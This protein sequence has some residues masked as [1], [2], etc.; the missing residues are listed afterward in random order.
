MNAR[1]KSSCMKEVMRMAVYICKNCKTSFNYNLPAHIS[2]NKK[3]KVSLALS[4]LQNGTIEKSAIQKNSHGYILDVSLHYSKIRPV[5]P[6]CLKND[7]VN[8]IHAK[9][10]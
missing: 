6:I 10:Q 1:A 3:A 2:K 7:S 9:K 5:C 4:M 8:W